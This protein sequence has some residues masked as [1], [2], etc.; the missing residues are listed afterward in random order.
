MTKDYTPKYHL[1]IGLTARDMST[2]KAFEPDRVWVPDP[3]VNV[4][5]RVI[6]DGDMWEEWGEHAI[7]HSDY[8]GQPPLFHV[9]IE[10]TSRAHGFKLLNE[11]LR[12]NK[13]DG[14]E[15]LTLMPAR[16]PEQFNEVIAVLTH[17]DD[18]SRRIWSVEGW[19]LHDQE[20]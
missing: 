9:V 7:N 6:V 16:Y 18:W 4:E 3:G 13:M 17:A 8:Q 20:A 5:P 19:A 11:L 2:V 15:R 14:L 1:H 12:W 10:A